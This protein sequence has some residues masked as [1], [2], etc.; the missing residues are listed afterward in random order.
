MIDP[1]T[2]RI[3][4]ENLRNNGFTT[5]QEKLLGVVLAELRAM[6]DETVDLG[7]RKHRLAVRKELNRLHRHYEKTLERESEASAGSDESEILD[8]VRNHLAPLGLAVEGTP[9]EELARLA[10]LKITEK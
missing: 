7:E 5:A 4:I 10:A 3:V 9:V 8:E 6:F 2:V 1:T